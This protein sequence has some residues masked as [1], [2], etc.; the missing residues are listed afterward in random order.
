MWPTDAQ[1]GVEVVT[2]PPRRLTVVT[3]QPTAHAAEV[4]GFAEVQPR[5]T[6]TLRAEVGGRLTSIS[7]ELQPG[8]RVRS[9]EVLATID[10]T[11]WRANLSEAKNRVATAELELLRAR[12]TADEAR[13]AWDESGL[14]GEPTSPLALHAPQV[15]A[16]HAE[17]DAAEEA[18]RWAA[19]RLEQTTVRAPF[20]ALVETASV[21]LGETVLE[22]QPI[23]TLLSTEALRIA[24][25]LS[26]EQ[27]ANLPDPPLHA[28]GTL[29]SSGG[30]TLGRATVLHGG[31]AFDR[32][33]RTRTLHLEVSEALESELLPGAFVEV[34]L[35]G[36]TVPGLLRLPEAVL[37]RSGT[38]WYLDTG[39][40]LRRYSV[41]PVFSTPGYIYVP[42]PEGAEAP[43]RI[44]R[45][46]LDTFLVGTVVEPNLD[47][48]GG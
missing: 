47:A 19:A 2:S 14:R 24:L 1:S 33:T 26:D 7:D 17:F 3:A 40:A 15:A 11:A 12:Q 5:W 4:S 29:H 25:P 21:S 38:I 46:P 35:R 37:T 16:A 34:R 8:S 45:Y 6:S 18:Y 31:G 10:P 32:S 43:W 23:V 20:D 28:E 13:R 42:P 27:W 44:A 41:R 30:D 39:D 48:G 9:G 22:G 36:R